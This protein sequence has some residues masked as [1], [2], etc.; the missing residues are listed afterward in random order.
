MTQHEPRLIRETGLAARIAALAEPVIEALGYRLVRVK[1]SSQNGTTLQIMAER[2]DGTMSVGDC[3]QVSRALSPVL[4]EKD[5]VAGACYMEMSSP[6]IDRP[7]VRAGDFQTWAGHEARVDMEV[8]VEGRKR[9]RGILLG[10]EGHTA[11]LRRNDAK[12]GEPTD[13]DLPIPDMENAR[14]VLTD[15]L[16]REALTRAKAAAKARGD[17]LGEA[18]LDEA[19][20]EIVIEGETPE[21]DDSAP[22]ARPAP[23]PKG[24]AK[25][26]GP[27]RY[28]RPATRPTTRPGRAR[29]A[30]P[31]PN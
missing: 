12:P 15:A 19:E 8:P 11:R 28:A 17:E 7:L 31:R 14:L 22:A 1:L 10:A 29:P 16:V 3:Q 23:G 24:G 13:F 20:D 30:K 9:F 4:E 2:P 25:P 18:G 5:P 26:K 27:G 21:A 6:G